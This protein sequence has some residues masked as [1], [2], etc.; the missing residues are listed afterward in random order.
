MTSPQV[1]TPTSSNKLQN[2][3]A[4]PTFMDHILELRGRLF[5]VAIIFLVTSAAAYPFR[6]VIIAV[7]TAPLGS[8]DLVYITPSGGFSFIIKVCTYAGAIL[9][10]PALIFHLYRYLQPLIGRVK[11]RVMFMYVFASS[12]LAGSGVAFAYFV[13]LP[14]ALHFLTGFDL[15][16]VTAMLTVDSYFSFVVA[17]T[18]AAAILFQL[19]LVL[20]IINSIKPLKP[21]GLMKYQRYV[22]LGAFVAAAV[23]SPTPDATN[24]ALLAVPIIVMY[25][26]GIIL[27]AIRNG[28]YKSNSAKKHPTSYTKSQKSTSVFKKSV[29]NTPTD[30]VFDK[31]DDITSELD[32]A[33]TPLPLSK[34]KVMDIMTTA[35]VKHPI[36]SS[37]K[38]GATP[39]SRSVPRRPIN[40]RYISDVM[41]RHDSRRSRQTNYYGLNNSDTKSER[42]ALDMNS[43]PT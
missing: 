41:N 5:W 26:I 20:L 2:Q 40:Q 15:Q 21:S 12:I 39:V 11:G 7:I 19:P 29:V 18:L 32:K 36:N 33:D 3:T 24:Q 10:L 9:T 31:F 22:I 8:Q 16:N 28:F 1:P 37:I 27:V 30:F 4:L 6:D 34:S 25:Q 17:Y 43:V 38:S 23:I 14:A 42:P 35:G 13:S